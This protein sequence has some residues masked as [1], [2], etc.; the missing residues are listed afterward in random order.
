M[1]VRELRLAS[2][3][4]VAAG[5]VPLVATLAQPSLPVPSGGLTSPG[6]PRSSWLPLPGPTNPR[7]ETLLYEASPSELRPRG[8]NWNTVAVS[9]DGKTLATTHGQPNGDTKG[10]LRLWDRET[11]KV[12]KSVSEP[13][14]TTAAAYSP[15]G[16]VLATTNYDGFLRLYDAA[17][18]TLWATSSQLPNQTNGLNELCFFRDGQYVATAGLDNVVRVWDVA[19]AREKR[20][21][22]KDITLVSV[23]SFEGHQQAVV[24]VAVSG[25]GKTLISGG[26]DQMPRLWDIPA[27]LPKTGDKPLAVKKERVILQAQGQQIQVQAV[28]ASPDGTLFVT[29]GA[30]NQLRTWTADGKLA[31]IAGAF[32][33][34]VTS[35]A[36]S[37]DGKLLAA[38][39]GQV[40]GGGQP[41]DVRVWHIAEKRE[42][43]YRSD[44]TEAV[45]GLAFTP[46]GKTL[47]LVGDDQAIRLWD[48]A[49]KK[50]DRV[51]RPDGLAYEAQPISA[52]A[53]HGQL[54]AIAGDAKAVSIYH[55]GD[56][57]LVAQLTGHGDTV[58]GVAFSPDGKTLATASHDRTVKLWDAATWKERKTLAGHA[59]WVYGVAF[60]PDGKTL[61][62]ASYDKSVRLWDAATGEAKATWREHTAGVRTVAFDRDGKFLAS[63]GSDRIVRVWDVAE[64]KVVQQLKGHKGP[65]RTV[66]FSP[67]NRTLV[68]G[69]EDRGVKFWDRATG[70]ETRTLSALPD[71][72]TMV[73]YSPKGQTLAVATYGG[74][75]VIYDPLSGRRRQELSSHGD[76]A[77]AAIF[78]DGGTKLVTA[79]LDRTVR[80]W[81]AVAPGTVAALQTFGKNATYTAVGVSP[82]G[83]TAVLGGLDGTLTAWHFKTGEAQ[84]LPQSH[85]GGVAKVVVGPGGQVASCGTDDNKVIVAT[86]GEKSEKTWTAVGRGACF[87]PDGLHIAIVRGKDVILCEAATGK[88]VRTFAGGHDG[89]VRVAA[90][91][92]KGTI[93]A[94]AGEDTKIR[95]WTVATAEKKQASAP[96]MNYTT[97]SQILFNPEGTAMAVVANSP[98]AAPPDDMMGFQ[99][100]RSVYVFLL[101]KG[102]T[103][104]EAMNAQNGPPQFMNNYP[105]NVEIAGAGWTRDGKKLFIAS[106][107]GLVRVFEAGTPES[108]N[109]PIVQQFRG[110]D[111]PVLAAGLSEDGSAFVTAGED[112]LVKRWRVPGAEP[113]PGLTRLTPPGLGRVWEAL[114]SPDGKFFVAAGGGDKAF[115]VY[116]A[117]PH[118]LPVEPD[119]L[120]A[121]MALAY[122]P[123]NKFLVTGHDRGIV[124]VRDA[125]TGKPIRRLPGL[126]KRVASLAFAEKGA[127]LVAVGG[128]WMDG[129]EA[130]E[131]V[132]WNFAEGTVRHKL[133]APCL[134]WMTAV[135]PS[136]ALA[137]GAGNDGTVRVWDVATGKV[138]HTLAKG[139][140]LYTVAY[141]ADGSR[142]A[143]ASSDGNVRVWDT[144]RG[145]V[146]REIK[147][148]ENLRASQALFSPDGKELVVS[149]WRGSDKPERAPTITA[150]R[151]DEA[152]AVPRD[153][154]AHP[155]SVMNLA[156]LPDGKT[157]IAAGGIENG[158]GSLRVYDYAAG[159]LLG[160]FRGHTHWGQNLAVRPDG[161][162]VASTSWGNPLTGELRLWDARGF[163]PAATVPMPDE[164]EYVSAGAISPDSKLLI[165]GGWGKTLTAWDMTDPTKPV[166][167]AKLSGHTGGLRSVDFN[168]DGSRF[169]TSDEAGFV[170]IWDS[171]AIAELSSWK[172]SDQGV[173]RAKFTPDGKWIVTC[174]GNWQAKARG[175][176][177][178]WDAKTGKETTRFPDQSREVWDIVFLQG[179]KK[180][181]T[182]GT[183][184]GNN[185]DD[186]HLKVWDFETRGQEA[187]PL[188]VNAFQAARSL[189]VTPD[190][191]HLALGSSNGPVKVF[192]TAGWQEV[193]SVTE[194]KNVCFRLQFSPDGSSLAVASGDS[195]AVRFRMPWAK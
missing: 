69:S 85:P 86:L 36:F 26:G 173:Y 77:T 143:A 148:N 191:K 160:D 139:G 145:E 180:M 142:L 176:I 172:A 150:Y 147:L 157:L 119:R 63:A 195:A 4:A 24:A 115:R 60:S 29:G 22:K 41:G 175:E 104:K 1:S 37:P 116:T 131:A 194:L 188:D 30:D 114:H 124:V 64:G 100:I 164:K 105:I 13:K 181:V 153:F 186:A 78:A 155:A 118:D 55:R 23:A 96:L 18:G 168:A 32:R 179:G 107:D 110:H 141:N 108:Q 156:F 163:R 193:L 72:V 57:K 174:S 182:S 125:A 87:S 9:P 159:K 80:E 7:G 52:V 31:E 123:D 74:T 82:D 177:R 10:E 54:V 50:D 134:Q 42:L 189:A 138:S 102:P 44:L 185:G 65:V 165:L 5:L 140:G 149:M 136:G 83:Q 129:N 6:P 151:L 162:A 53:V 40:G 117:L 14:G 127:A 33:A 89:S 21:A 113:V 12:R 91:D 20:Q 171:A 106:N 101:P 39:A 43:V 178:V 76:A 120:P 130:G 166:Q 95:F 28:A 94:T 49:E 70:K 187:T 169:V 81:P 11:G 103:D 92:P 84:V 192:E 3:L 68:S 99:V 109:K 16:K 15:D 183:I 158:K 98:D 71:M 79:S 25:D 27:T 88:E 62:S 146:A 67:D 38:S 137:A 48:H 93:L 47:A 154:P 2:L 128:N 112:M 19:A 133:D 111:A 8:V 184:S 122:S 132:V 34:V 126:E 73:R 75:V 66:A 167:K 46:D 121:V 90:F 58:S 59:G 190:G 17:T 97:I 35:I 56:A 170:R 61:A 161:K 152:T 144:A 51:L 135:H 45:G